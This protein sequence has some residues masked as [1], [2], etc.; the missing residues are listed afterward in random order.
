MTGPCCLPSCY[1]VSL[2]GCVLRDLLV[3][4]AR[5]PGGREEASFVCRLG[6]IQVRRLGTVRWPRA[7][8]TQQL[9]TR[10]AQRASG[11]EVP[12]SGTVQGRAPRTSGGLWDWGEPSLFCQVVDAKSLLAP[13]PRVQAVTVSRVRWQRAV[14]E[15]EG[16]P[17]RLLL[18]CTLHWSYLLSP[19]RCFRVHCRTGTGGGSPGG[20]PPGPEKPALL[21]LAFVNQYRIAELPVAASGPSGD[22]RVE[23]LVEPVPKEGF[24]VPQAEWGRAALLYSMP[25]T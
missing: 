25:H 5:P 13:L 20:G 6:E 10:S 12:G 8:I 1:E 15:E 22:G 7:P 23:F 4:F 18:G 3:S 11:V 24:L 16:P 17:A 2:R 14:P 19:V 9:D 21:G